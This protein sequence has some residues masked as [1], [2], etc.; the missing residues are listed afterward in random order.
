MPCMINATVE[1][2]PALS[3]SNIKGIY[4]DGIFGGGR[5][6]SQLGISDTCHIILDHHHLL[7]DDIGAWPTKIWPA[8]NVAVQ[9]AN[10]IENRKKE[11][12]GKWI[13]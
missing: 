3:L 11:L 1:M 6:L 8:Y 12:F 5:L 9:L 7:S 13:T 10:S 2:T 4:G